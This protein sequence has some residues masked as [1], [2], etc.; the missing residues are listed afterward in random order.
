M[1]SPTM[2]E[3]V[4]KAAPNAQRL[5]LYS[6]GNNAIL[7]SWSEI[8]GLGQ[9]RKL[10]DIR[11]FISHG[12]EPEARTRMYMNEFMQRMHVNCPFAK[13]RCKVQ[14]D[15]GLE[16]DNFSGGGLVEIDS[17]LGKLDRFA[18]F[19]QNLDPDKIPRSTVKVAVIDDGINIL[20]GGF[21][22]S[23]R[24]GVFFYTS[25]GTSVSRPY[26]FSS[27]G[28]GTLMANLIKR[29]CPIEQL[30][31]ARLDTK[32]DTK[33]LTA[34]SASKARHASFCTHR[35]SC[36]MASK[37]IRW[38]IMQEFD[39]IS[40]SWAVEEANAKGVLMF[41][42][43]SAQADSLPASIPGVICIGPSN[44]HGAVWELAPM[45]HPDF[46]F[47]VNDYGIESSYG[48][49]KANANSERV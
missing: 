29:V 8:D 28:H 22:D 37:A 4:R 15:V 44:P 45:Q 38:P 18:E 33:Q 12:V 7:R 20:Q 5:V 10:T 26:Y 30:Y 21:D 34:T 3:V 23:I 16:A 9:L 6:S 40:M 2:I 24:G 35:I 25:P 14:K 32:N 17:L 48:H 41:G 47:P 11:I 43:S 1:N 49:Q 31:I 13:I 39:I 42:S 19:L 46:F 27:S 36:L